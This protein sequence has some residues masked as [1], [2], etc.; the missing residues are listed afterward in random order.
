M[1]RPAIAILALLLAASG[2]GGDDS[3]DGGGGAPAEGEGEGPAEGEGEGPAEGEGEGPGEGEG[4]GASG[5]VGGLFFSEYVEGGADNKAVEVYNAGA[6]SAPLEGC[7]VLVYRN[8][9]ADAPET[10]DLQGEVAAGAAHVVCHGKLTDKTA[11]SQLDSDL[12]HNGDDAIALVCNG[13]TLDVIGQIGV[14][15]DEAWGTEQV[16]TKDMTL[17]RKCG[18]RAGDPEGGDPFDPAL[19]WDA[20]P[21]D[22]LDGLG[23]HAAGC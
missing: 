12:N 8:G 6:A 22:T 7:A 16:G 4:E 17:R 3:T 15:P 13:A 11:C 18:V 2:C 14:D 20:F 10:I 19:E 9:A 23:S 5:D 1:L 21:K